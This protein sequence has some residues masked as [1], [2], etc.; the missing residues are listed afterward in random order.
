M[1]RS[2]IR[3]LGEVNLWVKDADEMRRFYVDVLGLTPIHESKRHI[4]LKVADGYEGHPQ[5]VA[6]FDST[7]E[8][9]GVKPDIGRTT[10]NHVAF[11]IPLRSYESEKKRLKKLGLRP[12]EQ[13]HREA[14]WRSLY[15]HDPDGNQIEFVAFDKNLK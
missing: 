15:F 4:F 13:L 11:E 8:G 9:V 10:L 6:L 14:H 5:V 7:F 2:T 1:A 12:S 3:G